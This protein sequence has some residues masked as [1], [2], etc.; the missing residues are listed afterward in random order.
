MTNSP[1]T[2]QTFNRIQLM[3]N[4]SPISWVRK[5]PN[6]QGAKSVSTLQSCLQVW[7][8]TEYHLWPC[9][10]L[11]HIEYV[12]TVHHHCMNY[13][14]KS[15]LEIRQHFYAA[16]ICN[17][18][19]QPQVDGHWKVVIIASQII[20]R[21]KTECQQTLTGEAAKLAFKGCF[22]TLTLEWMWLP[23]MSWQSNPWRTTKRL[24]VPRALVIDSSSWRASEYKFFKAFRVLLQVLQQCSFY[25]SWSIS[26]RYTEGPQGCPGA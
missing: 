15:L 1:W 5:C 18:F 8:S 14:R 19:R 13:G 16:S 21:I 6:V 24:Q 23:W 10:E 17:T 7:F 12:G 20:S 3:T 22:P 4:Y 2:F 25:G 26:N 11:C 9:P